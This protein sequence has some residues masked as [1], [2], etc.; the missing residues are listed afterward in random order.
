MQLRRGSL[1]GAGGL[2]RRPEPGVDPSQVGRLLRQLLQV[3]EVEPQR[4]WESEYVIDFGDQWD[5]SISR[6]ASA[7]WF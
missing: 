2:L 3:P 5:Q 7:Q 4:E 6:D 1:R